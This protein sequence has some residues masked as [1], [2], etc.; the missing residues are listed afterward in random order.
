MK[1]KSNSRNYRFYYAIPPSPGP[2]GPGDFFVFLLSPFPI[3]PLKKSS[4]Y[5]AVY[6]VGLSI[7]G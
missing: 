6:D 5:Q 7:G 1:Y 4:Y 2:S 3:D